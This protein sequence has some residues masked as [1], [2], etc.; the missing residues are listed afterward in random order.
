MAKQ[1]ISKCK[2]WR[3]AEDLTQEQAAQRFHMERAS[4]NRI[5]NGLTVPRAET[6]IEIY[7]ETGGQIVPNDYF[8]LPDLR[9]GKA[10]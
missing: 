2:A 6:M 8:D 5:E 1:I 9:I 10:A 3:R 4:W 7:I